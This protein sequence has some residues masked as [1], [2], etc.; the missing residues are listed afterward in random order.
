MF[1]DAM[2]NKALINPDRTALPIIQVFRKRIFRVFW[3]NL[4]EE[5]ETIDS[6]KI[7]IQYERL[8]HE[9]HG[10]SHHVDAR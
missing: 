8:L 2:R 5:G 6:Q 1:Y 10:Y 3:L 4:R 9:T 7:L